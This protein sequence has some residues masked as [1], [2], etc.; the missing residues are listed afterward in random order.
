MDACLAEQEFDPPPSDSNQALDESSRNLCPTQTLVDL[1]DSAAH[2]SELNRDRSS[3]FDS[4]STCCDGTVDGQSDF[5]LYLSADSSHSS[6]VKNVPSNSF[7]HWSSTPWDSRRRAVAS[8]WRDWRLTSDNKPS[9]SEWG[10]SE[11][12]FS[13]S[14]AKSSELGCFYEANLPMVGA[15]LANLGNTCFLNAVLQCF[16]HTV[17]L[18]RGLRLYSH[19]KPC[20]RDSRGFCVVCA[21]HDLF[22]LLLASTGRVVSPGKLVDNLSYISCNFQRSQQEDA[23]EFLQCLLDRLETCCTCSMMKDAAL[24][25][26]DENLVKQVFGGRLLSKLQCCNCGYCSETYEPLIDLSLEIEDADTLPSALESFTKVEKIADQDIKFT[27]EKCKQEV[28]VEKQLLLD[29]VPSVAMFHLKRFKN[30]GSYV[31]KIDKHVEFPLELD[32]LPYYTGGD[33]NNNVELKYDLYAIIV[34]IGFSSTSGH[35]YCLIRCGPDAWYRLDDSKVT[36]VAEEFALSQEAYI[37]FYA[38]QGT[39]WFSSFIET[40]KSSFSSYFSNN[41]PKSVLDSMDHICMSSPAMHYNHSS[42]LIEAREDTTGNSPP[43]HNEWRHDRVEGN[44]GK[45]D[46]P[47]VVVPQPEGLNNFSSGMSC[48]VERR[49]SPDLRDGN[50]EASKVKSSTNI[51]PTPPRSPSPDIYADERPEAYSVPRSL[52]ISEKQVP[53]KRQ[54]NKDLDD[55]E[56]KQAVKLLK[57]MPGGRSSK[58]LAAMNRSNG[59]GHPNSKRSRRTDL[60]SNRNGPSST[61]HKPNLRSSVRPVAAGGL[62]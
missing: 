2:P 4:V 26:A 12:W 62:R 47:S 48:N 10:C 19:P 1:L 16:T 44:E 5:A 7:S 39:P 30:N 42:G 57:A 43:S 21:L 60:T 17:P 58:L 3:N 18:V 14:D 46:S 37:L 15:G 41:S 13:G 36:R 54:L 45:D 59:E 27:C 40:E 6:A 56:R 55:P 52:R 33:Q 32:L 61:G 35:Y 38:K 11:T 23:H 50:P 34:H 24:P 31:E 49:V 22:E 20:E 9:A 53:C 51:S 8:G 25:L 28:S 29:Q